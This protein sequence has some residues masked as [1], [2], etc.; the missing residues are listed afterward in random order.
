M[1]ELKIKKIQPLFTRIVTTADEYLEQEAMLASGIIDTSKL[2]KGYKEYQTVIEVGTSCRFVKPGDIVCIN[3]QRY[4]RSK[5]VKEPREDIDVE[6][7]TPT[8]LFPMVKLT[9]DDNIE[10]D[11]LFLDEG[12]IEFIVV[13]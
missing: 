1:A 7:Q 6:L 11:F 13:E 9:G 5:F 10:R 12:D 8:Y 3:P 2:R 4:L